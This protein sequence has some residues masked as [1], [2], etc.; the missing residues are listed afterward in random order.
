[1]RP[2][3]SGETMDYRQRLF[4]SYYTTH[5]A[6]FAKSDPEQVRLLHE[7]YDRTF[8]PFLPRDP[9]ASIL[10]VGCGTGSM[11]LFLKKKGFR[12]VSGVD[13]SP[14]QVERSRACGPFQVEVSEG[15]SYLE[16]HPGAFDMIFALDIFEHLRKEDVLPMLDA[17]RSSLRPGGR[18]AIATVNGAGLTAGRLLYG[19]FTHELAYTEASLRQLF[20]ATGL[21]TVR[22]LPGLPVEL[23]TGFRGWIRKAIWRAFD[24]LAHLYLHATT[25]SG[26][27]HSDHI[28]SDGIFAV[29]EKPLPR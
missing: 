4:D 23:W 18:L 10:D 29:A 9:E 20:A 5:F 6:R 19:D 7:V 25:S 28:L 15:R 27:L 14:Q 13:V 8:G 21:E 12:R 11:L 24:L 1:M 26:I 2:A 3:P 17:V 16:G 22:V